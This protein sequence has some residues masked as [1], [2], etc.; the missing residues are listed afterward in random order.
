MSATRSPGSAQPSPAAAPAPPLLDQLLFGAIVAILAARAMIGEGFE[1]LELSFIEAIAPSGGPTPATTAVLDFFLLTA[2]VLVLTRRGRWRSNWLLATAIVFLD[3]AVALS[4]LFAANSYLAQ[5]AGASLLAGVLGGTALASL[6]RHPSLHRLLL[7][8]LLATGATT[9]VKCVRQVWSE[10]PDMQRT[11]QQEYAPELVRRGYDLNDP[12]LVNYARRLESQEAYGF[13]SHPNVTGSVLAMCLLVLAGVF[14]VRRAPPQTNTAQPRRPGEIDL[15]KLAPIVA[16]VGCTLLAYAMWLT[17]SLGALASALAGLILLLALGFT[18]R[19]SA[20]H[21]RLV[22]AIL[23][24]GYVAVVAAVAAYGIRNGTLP[25]P[26][27]EFRWYYWTAAARAYEDVPLT[28]LGRGNFPAAYLLY[29][30]PESTEE[31]RDPHNLWVSLLVELGPSGLIAGALLSI[32]ALLAALR[33]LAPPEPPNQPHT[34]SHTNLPGAA[35]LAIAV[36][37]LHAPISGNLAGPWPLALIWATDVAFVWLVAFALALWLLRPL[38]FSAAPARWLAAGLCGAL[39][40]LLIH[41]LLDFT[42]MTPGGLAFTV[43]CAA[44][45]ATAT[46]RSAAAPQSKPQR[47]LS[48]LILAAGAFAIAAQAHVTYAVMSTEHRVHNLRT[49]LPAA[50]QLADAALSILNDTSCDPAAAGTSLSALLKTGQAPQLT[51]AARLDWYTRAYDTGAAA[52]QRKGLATTGN[53]A[54]LARLANGAA[55]AHDQL[56]HTTDADAARLA[57]AR[58]WDRASELYPTNPRT[59]ISAGLA[60]LEVWKSTPT[61]DTAARI[62]AHLDAALRVNAARK[63]E[64]STRLRLDELQAIDSALLHLAARTTITAPATHP[65]HTP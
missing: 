24:A 53:Y 40:A 26:S 44:C 36:L 7:A 63:P 37:V 4:S 1:R 56:G 8:A 62:R 11:W 43:L 5:F 47:W 32:A 18:A 17:G 45:A 14:A 61:P 19:W 48:T 16:V 55:D 60:W 12:L 35:L 29:K 25:H 13:L 52:L 50:P 38:D 21:T 59:H 42:L 9:A 6:A 51:A 28:G 3:V 2:S 34:A 64:E 46:R 58:A 20:R 33:R 57:A 54:L 31:V 39:A 49:L 41:S 23:A 65:A 15:N 10:F 22:V 30:A 27:L